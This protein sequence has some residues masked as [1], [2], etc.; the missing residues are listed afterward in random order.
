VIYNHRLDITDNILKQLNAGVPASP[1]AA[2]PTVG[3]ATKQG[4][5][6]PGGKLR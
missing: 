6:Q 5:P 4:A 1:A 3:T 2:A